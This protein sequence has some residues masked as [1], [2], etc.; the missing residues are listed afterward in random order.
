MY[1]YD[2]YICAAHSDEALALRLAESIKRYKLPGKTTPAAN[3][4]GYSNIYIDTAERDFD[5]EAA[6]LLDKSRCFLLLCSPRSQH[7]EPIVSRLNYFEAA[8]GKEYIIA[9]LI[10]GEPL[11]AFPDNF[12]EQKLVERMR[13]DGSIVQELQTVEPVAADLRGQS[14]RHFK[15]LLRYET[16]RIVATLLELKPDE[17]EKRHQKRLKRRVTVLA[18]AGIAILLVIAAIIGYFALQA[19]REGDVA[20]SQTNLSLALADRLMTELPEAFSDYPEVKL[21]IYDALLDSITSLYLSGSVNLSAIDAA[22]VLQLNAD[23]SHDLMLR[24]AVALRL[25]GDSGAPEAY[26]QALE[27]APVSADVLSKIQELLPFWISG[28]TDMS[29]NIT[30]PYAPSVFLTAATES[31]QAGDIIGLVDGEAVGSHID[32]QAYLETLMPE[33]ELTLNV[34]RLYGDGFMGHTIVLK[35]GELLGLAAL[36]I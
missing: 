23:D 9:V 7:C 3:G 32:W 15:Q 11:D 21:Y 16:V 27:N 25:I 8:R 4:L 24:K 36:S 13:A 28:E 20:S 12:I 19:R 6:L 29:T 26:K 1:E 35:A 14:N 33:Q 17:L 34:Y 31:L 10:E 2:V 22:E 5:D 18:S 30:T